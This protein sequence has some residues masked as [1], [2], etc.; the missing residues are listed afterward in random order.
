MMIALKTAIEVKPMSETV[1]P[2]A[3]KYEFTDEHNRLFS[4]LAGSMGAAATLLQLLGL[5]LT[6][7]A[8]LQGMNSQRDLMS[9]GPV[10]GLTAGG[11]LCLSFGFWTSG[12]ARSFRKVAETKNEDL[13]HLMNALGSLLNMYSLVRTIIYGSLVLGAVGL[14]LLALKATGK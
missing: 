5:I 1:P 10:V 7:L 14:V 8:I 6:V 3:N 2:A 4:A 9:F 13:W 12:A 11:I